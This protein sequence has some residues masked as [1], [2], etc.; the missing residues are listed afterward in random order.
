MCL[1]AEMGQPVRLALLVLVYHV[2][3]TLVIV[4]GHVA[5]DGVEAPVWPSGLLEKNPAASTFMDTHEFHATPRATPQ[6]VQVYVKFQV[7]VLGEK[8]GTT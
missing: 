1:L 4:Q 2:V 8:E 6:S 5:A 3:K 7:L